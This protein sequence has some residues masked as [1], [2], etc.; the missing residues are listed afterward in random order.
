MPREGVFVGFTSSRMAIRIAAISS[1]CFADSFL[2]LLQLLHELFVRSGCRSQVREGADHVNT[3]LDRPSTSKHHR[4]HNRAMLGKRDRRFARIAMSG[5]VCI[6]GEFAQLE[7]FPCRKTECEVSKPKVLAESGR[8]WES[9]CSWS[10]K[11]KA[12][13][14]MGLN[15]NLPLS[16]KR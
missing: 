5:G 1:S 2:E 13:F 9:M 12:N 14:P 16:V 4:Q 6:A 3:H 10:K 11:E 7:G 15:R 8:G